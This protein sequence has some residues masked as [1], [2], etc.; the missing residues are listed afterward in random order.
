M[1]TH[2]THARSLLA[3]L[4]LAATLAPAGAAFAQEDAI[5]LGGDEGPAARSCPNLQI[6]PRELFEEYMSA[7][8]DAG[9]T[10]FSYF[11]CGPAC[12]AYEQ[13]RAKKQPITAAMT[14]FHDRLRRL[15]ELLGGQ[16]TQAFYGKA[17]PSTYVMLS[18]ALASRSA[19]HE[20]AKLAGIDCN[21]FT[22]NFAARNGWGWAHANVDPPAYAN[23]PHVQN[24]RDICPGDFI[25]YTGA[26]HVAVVGERVGQHV[27]TKNGRSVSLATFHV[28]ESASDGTPTGMQDTVQGIDLTGV[29]RFKLYHYNQPSR[30]RSADPK[31]DGWNNVV[32]VPGPGS[33]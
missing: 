12:K 33:L 15:G 7:A 11:S 19:E 16:A 3:A 31:E 2:R 28:Y 5:D 10:S 4:A 6:E 30:A 32:V 21:G 26:R 9:T 17:P 18:Q 27:I 22:T 20:W 13:A 14:P 23:R 1:R 8:R 24:T 29:D 25:V